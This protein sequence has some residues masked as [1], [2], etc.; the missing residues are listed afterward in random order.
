LKYDVGNF[1]NHN[2]QDFELK[3]QDLFRQELQ[4]YSP[5][6]QEKLH[7]EFANRSEITIANPAIATYHIDQ[8]DPNVTVTYYDDFQVI[9]DQY[10]DSLQTDIMV[11]NPI[12]YF[13]LTYS[14]RDFGDDII[15]NTHIALN[16]T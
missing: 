4:V 10:S 2:R 1:Y 3:T 11:G 8:T 7:Y 16:S 14:V 15:Q 6:T 13:A 9:L 5:K 12:I